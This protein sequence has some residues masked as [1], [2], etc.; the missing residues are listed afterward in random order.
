MVTLCKR[1]GK[2]R[3][4]VKKAA[5]EPELSVVFKRLYVA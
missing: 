4:H 5:C 3:R 1:V 2:N